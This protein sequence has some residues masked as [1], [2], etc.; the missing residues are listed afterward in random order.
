MS[1]IT[2]K[3]KCAFLNF[4]IDNVRFGKYKSQNMR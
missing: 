1:A 3:Q 2:I 4:V